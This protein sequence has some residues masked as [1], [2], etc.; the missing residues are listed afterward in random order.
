M[1]VFMCTFIYKYTRKTF[2]MLFHIY[3]RIATKQNIKNEREK[4]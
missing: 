3:N 2:V 1:N 4:T